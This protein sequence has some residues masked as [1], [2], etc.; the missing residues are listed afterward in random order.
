MPPVYKT[1][2][3]CWLRFC[4]VLCR[5]KQFCLWSH[6]T[7]GSLEC[8]CSWN[9]FYK[10]LRKMSSGGTQILMVWSK[11]QFVTLPKCAYF[12]L[13]KMPNIHQHCEHRGLFWWQLL[14]FLCLKIGCGCLL[15]SVLYVSKKWVPSS[16]ELHP[17]LYLSFF[18]FV[19]NYLKDLMNALQMVH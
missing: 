8:E 6:F 17:C 2:P 19:L 10:L 9:A 1:D 18:L 15:G 11:S 7:P 14:A 5:Q 4:T 16:S 3:A 12:T 13:A